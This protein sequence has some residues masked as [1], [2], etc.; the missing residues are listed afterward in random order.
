MPKPHTCVSRII[1]I[2]FSIHDLQT[3]KSFGSGI[4]PLS[5][6]PWI[7][8]KT[9]IFDTW[10]P[11]NRH[12]SVPNSQGV[13]VPLDWDHVWTEIFDGCQWIPLDRNCTWI[14]EKHDSETSTFF[15]WQV[16]GCWV[17]ALF[18]AC[19]TFLT[20][21]LLLASTTVS[22]NG[23]IGWNFWF[24]WYFGWKI[25]LSSFVRD[26]WQPATEKCHVSWHRAR[27]W[28]KSPGPHSERWLWY[29]HDKCFPEIPFTNHPCLWVLR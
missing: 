13:C 1:C 11:W 23:E 18:C 7:P 28:E 14:P 8:N 21:F 15:Q 17:F 2:V 10:T 24:F 29:I 6:D 22:E 27:W 16:R 3:F 25:S 5:F 12:V 19:L 20:L 9:D 4:P 26:Y